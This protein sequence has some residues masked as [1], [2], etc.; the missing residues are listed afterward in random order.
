MENYRGKFSR[1]DKNGEYT[2]NNLQEDIDC[3]TNTPN[4]ITSNTPTV[5]HEHGAVVDWVWYDSQKEAL[6]RDAKC[7][8]PASMTREMINTLETTYREELGQSTNT[9]NVI[10]TGH[11]AG[12]PASLKALATMYKEGY[13]PE[14][15]PTVVMLDGS[16]VSCR[17]TE[18]EKRILAEN[19]V[20]IIAYYQLDNQKLEY[21]SLGRQGL[22]IALIRDYDCHGHDAP[23]VNFFANS[24]G[25]FDFACGRGTLLPGTSGYTM[26]VWSNGEQV[27]TN[28]TN[29]YNISGVDTRDKLFAMWDINSFAYKVTTLQE[30]NAFSLTNLSFSINDSELSSSLSEIISKIGNTRFVNSGFDLSSSIGL[31]TVVKISELVTNY[32]VTTTDLLFHIANEMQEYTKIGPLLASTEKEIIENNN[33]ELAAGAI[34]LSES[35]INKPS[36]TESP[37]EEVIVEQ[38]SVP[39]IDETKNNQEVKEETKKETEIVEEKDNNKLQQENTQPTVNEQPKEEQKQPVVQNNPETNSKPHSNNNVS[40]GNNNKTHPLEQFPEYNEVY[41]DE[42]KIV[43]DYNNEYRI[44][45]HKDGD[46]IIGI[47]HYYKFGSETEATNA[48]NSLKLEYNDNI[49]MENIVQKGQYVKVIFKEEMYENLTIP[50]IRK[51]YSQLSEIVKL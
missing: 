7:V 22:N 6:G 46:E 47:E 14:T 33:N 15:P 23:S 4:N 25:I 28:G 19:N 24:K 16:F 32:F 2:Y 8:F 51:Q 45:V 31:Q 9:N 42:T 10:L 30:L 34:V 35:I 18:E 41:S 37:V 21:E 11:S 3:Y 39:K 50:E 29:R 43:Y 27:Y 1:P 38:P 5:I 40:S 36:V 49:N 13:K 44:I 48:L 12:G 26:S 17:L 20:P